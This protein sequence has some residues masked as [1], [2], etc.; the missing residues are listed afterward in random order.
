MG[1]QYILLKVAN[2]VEGRSVVA[3]VLN[4]TNKHGGEKSN[5]TKKTISQNLLFK[6]L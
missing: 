3:R 6:N 1:A 2:K 4:Y 5:D